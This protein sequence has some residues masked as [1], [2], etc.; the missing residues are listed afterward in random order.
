MERTAQY[1]NILTQAIIMKKSDQLV[2]YQAMLLPH[3]C[4]HQLDIL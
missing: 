2:Q 1:Q 3:S 4:L